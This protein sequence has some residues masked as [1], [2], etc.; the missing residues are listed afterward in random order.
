MTVILL[1]GNWYGC[2][3]ICLRF[4]F[5]CRFAFSSRLHFACLRSLPLRGDVSFCLVVLLIIYFV[6]FV[7]LR[8]RRVVVCIV[9]DLHLS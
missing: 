3:E 1:N 8:L 2:D 5:A 6:T 7:A 9:V 4:V